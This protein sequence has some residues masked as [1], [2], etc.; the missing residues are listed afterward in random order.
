MTTENKLRVALLAGG[1]SGEREVSLKGAEGVVDALDL[2]KYDVK[3]Y[4]PAID[5]AKLAGDA[6]EID[7]VFILL[8]GLFGE[9]GETFVGG[10][11]ASEPDRV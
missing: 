7:V 4:D 1:K 2:T 5:M 10:E 11:Q 9:D 3:R 6:K 8:H